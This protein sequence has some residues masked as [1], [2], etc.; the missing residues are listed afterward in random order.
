MCR[1]FGESVGHLLLHCEFAHE[2]W[3]VVFQ[4]FGI[5]WVMPE[6]VVSLLFGCEMVGET[7]FECSNLVPACL[8]WLVWTD[9]TATSLRMLRDLLIIKS[10]C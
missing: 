6:K 5:Q 1:C 9:G 3:S 8:M 7:F 2:F 10:P 4:M